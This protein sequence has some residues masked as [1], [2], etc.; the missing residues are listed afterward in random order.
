MSP[1]HQSIVNVYERSFE[2]YDLG[3]PVQEDMSVL[4]VSFSPETRR[5]VHVMRMEPGAATIPISTSAW[6]SS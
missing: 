1:N 3:G 2:P 6:R 5:G 4:K